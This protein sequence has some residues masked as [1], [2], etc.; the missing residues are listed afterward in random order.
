MKKNYL[1]FVVL[2]LGMLF[3]SPLFSQNQL[4]VSETGNDANNGSIDAPLATLVGARDRARETGIKTIL[5]RGGRYY[6]DETCNLSSQDNGITFSGYNDELVIFDGSKFIDPQAFETVTDPTILDKLNPNAAGHVKALKITNPDLVAVLEKSTAQISINDQMQTLARFPNR[7]FGHIDGNT[8][9]VSV[10]TPNTQGTINDPKGAKFK[11]LE[12]IDGTKW[13]EEFNTNKRAQIK[14]YL[15]ADWLKERNSIHSVSASGEIRFVN[16]TR[17]GLANRVNAV[18]RFFIYNILYELDEPGEWFF[19]T[20]DSMLYV[21]FKESI[22]QNTTLGAWAGPQLFEIKDASDITIKKMTVQNLGKQEGG[23]KGAVNITGSSNNILVAGMRFRFIAETMTAFNI[24][25]DVTNS[26]I[27]SCD[28]YDGGGSRLYGGKRTSTSVT[29]GNNKIENCHFTQVFSKD[30]YGKA[31]GINGAGNTFRNNLI[32]NINGQPVTHAGLDHRIERNELFN[33]GIEEGDGGAIYTGADMTSYGN[34]VSHNFIHHI[35]SVPGIFGRAGVYCDDRDGGEGIQENV[36]YKGGMFSVLIN[37]GNGHWVLDNVVL[38]GFVGM[39]TNSGGGEPQYDIAMNYINNDPTNPIKANYFGR[40]LYAVGIPGWQNGL[41]E[42]NWIDRIEPFWIERYPYFGYSMRKLYNNKT[43][44]PFETRFYNNMFF[45]TTNV[46]F[47]LA[48][49]AAERDTQEI[50]ESLF[51][52]AATMNYKFKEPRP[53]YAPNIP[54]QNI[55]LY[56]DEYRCAIPDKDTYRRNIKLRFEGQDCHSHSYNYDYLTI[57]D[58]LYYNTGE[59]VYE[60]V[61]CLDVLPEIAE[62][63]EYKFDLGTANSKVFPGYTRVSNVTKGIN[64]GWINTNSISALDR[65]TNGANDINRDLLYS[66]LSRLFEARVVNG[67]WNVLITFGDLSYSHDN[68]QV[69]AENEVVLTNVNT[70]PGVFVNR[71]FD[72]DIVDGKVSLEFSDLGGSDPNWV[73]TRIWLRYNGPILSTD[74]NALDDLVTLSP[75][76]A[77]SVLRL[78][79]SK[80]VNKATYE[81][82]DNLGRTIA[83]KSSISNKSHIDLSGFSSGLYFLKIKLDGQLITKRFIKK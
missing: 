41:N 49:G 69:K 26:T 78:T 13:N 70:Q 83:S 63:T 12:T 36:F 11:M 22:D 4:F 74:Q 76:P 68:I 62:E 14:G 37:S 5:I 16:G 67:S 66:N 61:P 72:V 34:S 7:G 71:S 80:S 75:N 25:R 53:S 10:E 79:Y 38:R 33:V 24:W 81:V 2:C 28:I 46:N 45:G 9:N 39:R 43:S 50:N 56:S 54:F 18:M 8:L 29:Y 55:G 51:V 27:L 3:S 42:N 59:M 31:C 21:W 15:S 48:P 47:Q 57:N 32:H 73:A 52:N 58:R 23:G 64:F 30:F 20:T 6:F 77:T 19:D 40:M 82:L 44:R 17:Y 60:T 65:G 35:M 1:L